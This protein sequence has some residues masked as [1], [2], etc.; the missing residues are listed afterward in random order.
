MSDD[1]LWDRSGKPDPDVERLEQILGTARYQ[2]PAVPRRTRSSFRGRVIWAAAAALLVATGV[3]TWQVTRVSPGSFPVTRLAGLPLVNE[4]PVKDSARLFPG[5]WLE[6]DARS[7]AEIRVANIGEVTVAPRSRLRL[8][9]TGP[10]GHR[11]ELARGEIQA[12]V[13]APPRLFVVDTP[14]A[15]AVD[16]GCAYTLTVDDQ[17]NSILRVT[18]GEVS[19]EGGGRSAIVVA[20]TLCQTRPH[21]P[22]GTP[23]S[24]DAPPAFREALASWDFGSG[25]EPA[26]HQALSVARK[27]D[28][29]SLWHLLTR[30]P[31]GDRPEVYA[32]LS[33]FVPPPK[34]VKPEEVNHLDQR[35]LDQWWGKVTDDR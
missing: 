1:Y 23:Y 8:V 28:S 9:S 13:L 34:S 14:S 22:P 30:V 7:G 10:A 32:K 16:L 21:Q 15:S 3:G 25:G 31:E 27:A 35:Q 19:L 24:D 11:L 33:S 26:L 12:R 29:V 2:A 17:G 20:G 18:R 4:Q 6:T 5:N